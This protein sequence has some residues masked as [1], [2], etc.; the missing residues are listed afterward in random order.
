MSRAPV[1]ETERLVLRGHTKAD[2]EVYAAIW[3]DPEVT[4]FIG[5]KPSTREETWSRLLRVI[6]HWEEMG[7]G[8]WAVCEKAS[9]RFVGDVGFANFQRA[10]EPPLGDAPEM[11][12]VFSPSAHGKGYASEAVAAAL[13]WGHANF[14]DARTVCIIDPDNTASLRVAEKAGYREYA[15]ADYRGPIILLERLGA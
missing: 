15:R 13:A 2:L 10:I 8:A 7:F 9:G 4:R 5:G 14:D 3:G 6:G 11:G 12:W 1:I